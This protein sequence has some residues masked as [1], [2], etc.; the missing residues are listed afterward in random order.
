MDITPPPISKHE[1]EA[2]IRVLMRSRMVRNW[3]KS[4]AAFFMLVEGT[5]EYD[6]FYKEHARKAAERIIKQ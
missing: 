1:H 2:A 3:V 4:E 6:K 5:P